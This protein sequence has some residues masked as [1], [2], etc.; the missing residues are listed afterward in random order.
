M[1]EIET[2]IRI[3]AD[4]ETIWNI[5]M[6]F[7]HYPDWNPFIKSIEGEQA[8]GSKLKVH[9]HPPEGKKMI[10]NPTIQEFVP[11]RKLKWLGSGP[12]KGLF[13]GQHSFELEQ[14]EDGTVKFIHEERFTG[15]L[16]GLFK[17]VLIK[18]EIGFKQMNEALKEKSEKSA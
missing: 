9:I 2:D 6:D 16:V 13:D 3:N 17:K 14:L 15:L 18:T 5:L 8:L 12:V 1:K 11:N 7:E 4:A 10:F